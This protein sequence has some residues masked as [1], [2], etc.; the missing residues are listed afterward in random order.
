MNLSAN[1]AGS[2]TGTHEIG[3]DSPSDTITLRH[4]ARNRE[5][6]AHGALLAARWIQNQSGL[7][8]FR[9]IVSQLGA[10]QSLV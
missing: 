6:Y 9:D 1:R 7:H 5:A 8:E 2:H 10:Q 3:F 4:T